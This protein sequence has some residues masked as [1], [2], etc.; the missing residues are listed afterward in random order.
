MWLREKEK[1][2]KVFRNNPDKI[3]IEYKISIQEPS[4]IDSTAVKDN[5]KADSSSS[6][7]I[8]TCIFMNN[9]VILFE[10]FN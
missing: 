6:R 1:I 5:P 2:N 10:F 7:E 3:P 8:K 9:Q 4:I